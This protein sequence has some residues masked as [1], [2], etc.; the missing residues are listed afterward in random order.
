MTE[1]REIGQGTTRM[2]FWRE[3]FGREFNTVRGVS[4]NQTRSHPHILISTD[5]FWG[6]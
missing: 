2:M 4:A 6:K 3:A 5:Q 1:I